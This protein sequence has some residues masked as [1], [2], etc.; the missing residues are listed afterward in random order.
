MSD[1]Y[2][3]DLAIAEGLKHWRVK[4]RLELTPVVAAKRL[5]WCRCRAY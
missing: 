4:K 5:L 1:S 2:I 3:R